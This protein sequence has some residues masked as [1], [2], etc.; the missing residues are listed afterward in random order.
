MIC[1]FTS[2][3]VI[4]KLKFL[5]TL[6]GT[7]PFL[8]MCSPAQLRVLEKNNAIVRNTLIAYDTFGYIS[9]S[10]ISKIHIAFYMFRIPFNDS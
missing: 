1:Q 4:Q 2:H 10:Y 6:H 9:T 8:F 7:A 5:K 3:L